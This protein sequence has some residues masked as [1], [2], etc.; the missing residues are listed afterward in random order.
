M[1]WYQACLLWIMAIFCNKIW[2]GGRNGFASL[3]LLVW[4]NTVE[5]KQG[6]SCILSQFASIWII[7]S[8]MH[9]SLIDFKWHYL[10]TEGG[11]RNALKFRNCP[12]YW[13]SDKG[14]AFKKESP[15]FTT[16][17]VHRKGCAKHIIS[18]TGWKGQHVS[19]VT[20][21]RGW[22][23]HSSDVRTSI[24]FLTDDVDF[25]CTLGWFT[26]HQLLRDIEIDEAICWHYQSQLCAWLQLQ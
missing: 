4:L 19:S 24:T 12:R 26:S 11:A 16:F 18:V 17:N 21:E 15:W 1:S 10:I 20:M 23:W 3:V 25:N 8:S 7:N 13:M 2:F 22:I 6:N 14:K 5:L 9:I